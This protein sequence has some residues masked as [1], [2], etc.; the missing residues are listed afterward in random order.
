[1]SS[2]DQRAG[3]TGDTHYQGRWI[4][5]AVLVLAVLLVAVDATVL[6]LATPFLSEDL[7][8]TGTQLLWIGD[9]YSF[10]IAGLLVS[11][12]SLGDRIGRK[13]LLL[14]GAT[15]FGAVSV[16]NAYA[17]SPE[18]MIVA[19]ALLGV[20]GATLMPSTLAL[21]RNLFHD[22]RERSL[23]VGIW[24]AMASAGAAVG[25]VVGGLL[26]EH[27][28]WGSVFLINLPVMAVL[29]AV[30]IKMIPESKNPAPGP[31]D[32]PSVGLSLVGMIGVVYA[33]KEAASHGV[34][35]GN[36]AAAVGG[37]LALTWFVRRQLKLPAPLLD[38]RL[39]HHRGFSGAVLADLLTILGLSGIVFFLS[40]FLQ[41]VQGRGP[42]EAGLAELPAAVGAVTAGLLAGRVARRYSV[43]S[44]VSL[45]LGAIGASLAVVTVIHK[46]TGYPLIGVLLLVV[47]VG[48]GF[49]FTVTSD[50]I[51]SS[52]PKEQA[53]SASA[54]SETAYELGA[55]L[56]IA[57]LG[58]VV[59][60]VYKGF[61]TPEGT[62]AAAAAA[63]HESLGGAVETAE[64]LPAE[65]GDSLVVAAQ[66]AFVNGLRVSAAVGAVVLLA[67]AVAAW[68]LLRDQK[69][70][71]GIVAD[72]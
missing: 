36:S 37:L 48:A 66:E 43:R 15:A 44:V 30:G 47:G 42:L 10:V 6:G 2:T 26:L 71:D 21:I 65:L 33:I 18:M 63:A 5:L 35:W 69:L 46:E 23:A 67:T 29:V 38:M 45:G 39:F 57:L 50:V 24:G 3:I 25:P 7:E 28:W 53:G 11:M 13:K 49:A 19:R 41:L 51:L 58:S 27:F 1:M 54:V 14:T 62:P 68:F 70:E 22:P 12:G 72:E 60:G 16:L 32:L 56:G 31:W 9:V 17:T 8:P 55:A 59:T 20:A 61:G 4:A 52:V 64:H 40:Q 34:S